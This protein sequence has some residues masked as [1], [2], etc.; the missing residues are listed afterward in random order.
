[1]SEHMYRHPQSVI[2]V[3]S[4]QLEEMHFGHSVKQGHSSEFKPDIIYCQSH[5]VPYMPFLIREGQI[6]ETCGKTKI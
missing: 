1:M 5:Y 4:E 2:Q 6:G 3:F